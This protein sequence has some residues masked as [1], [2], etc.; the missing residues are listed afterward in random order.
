MRRLLIPG[1]GA[2]ILLF[3]AAS[4]GYPLRPDSKDPEAALKGVNTWYSEQIKQAQAD[5]KTPDYNGLMKER[6]AKAKA[7]VE[8][9]D[10]SMAEPAKCFAWAQLYQAAQMPK[11]MQ[12]AAQRFVDSNPEPAA[13]FRA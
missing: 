3:S 2:L 8:G 1:F 13:K 12:A 4:F 9:I 6:T 10:I 7:A 11:E 5:K